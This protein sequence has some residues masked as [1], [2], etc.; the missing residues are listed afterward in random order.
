MVNLTEVSVEWTSLFRL[1]GDAWTCKHSVAQASVNNF[2]IDQSEKEHCVTYN[3]ADLKPSAPRGVDDWVTS[4]FISGYA[5]DDTVHVGCE[6]WILS[7]ASGVSSIC[8][9]VSK[10]V[11]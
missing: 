8:K 11:S 9:K 6:K 5:C 3:A 10:T 1:K 2:F 7:D 4:S